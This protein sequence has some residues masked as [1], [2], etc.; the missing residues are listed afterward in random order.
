MSM[1]RPA[2]VTASI[3]LTVGVLA[4]SGI[5]AL[6]T[7]VFE[8]ELLAAWRDGRSDTSSVQQ[9][10]FVPVALVMFVVMAMLM[11]VLLMFFREGHNWS[12]VL[13][14]AL[15]LLLGVATLAVLRTRPPALFMVLCSLSILLD[16]AAVWCLLHKDTR[17]WI[18]APVEEPVGS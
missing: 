6:L 8:D 17:A 4:V 11:T 16:L 18:N 13:I 15:I 3:W 7:L 14:I 1:Q 2:T 12:R 9:P 5:S 10:A